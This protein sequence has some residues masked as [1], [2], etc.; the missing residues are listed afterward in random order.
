MTDTEIPFYSTFSSIIRPVVSEEK[1]KY[2]SVASL[3]QIKAFI[4]NLD[5]KNN[6]DFLAIAFNACVVNRVNKNDDVIDTKTA[7]DIYKSFINTPINIEHNRKNIIG[8]I[9]TAGFSEF[10]SDKPLSE[11]QV[12]NLTS[13]FNITLGGLIWKTVSPKI[14]EVVEEASDPTSKNYLQVS[15]SWELKFTGYNL[16]ILPANQKN[17]E[18][19]QIIT[20]A[21]EIDK[22]KPLLRA[23]KG[24]GVLEDGR[25]LYREASVNVSAMGIGI[26]ENPAAEVKG[27]ATEITSSVVVEVKTPEKEEKVTP[28]ENNISQSSILPVTIERIKDMK[29][30]SLKDITNEN[31]KVIEASVISDFITS[32]FNSKS[33]EWEAEKS[34]LATQLSKAQEEAKRIADEQKKSADTIKN[35]EASVNAL[36]TEKAEREKVDKFNQ[37]MNEVSQAYDFD[38][39]VQEAVVEE[40]KSLSS[41]EEFAKWQKK[42]SLLLK[43]FA[44]KKV[45]ADESKAQESKASIE[46]AIDK[47]TKDKQTTPN[48]STTTQSLKEKYANAFA[49]ENITIKL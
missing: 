21:E 45:K 17:I 10:G 19:G 13:P 7:L 5:S 12:K 4:P 44:K 46:D 33:K 20:S 37:R 43:G 16:I 47:G 22:L 27:I 39:E 1:D 30:T 6:D 41:D 15:A 8:V 35:L 2:L 28:I 32:E 26:T 34:S 42:A 31:L 40:I 14:A 11:E 29:I 23:N 18:N 3:E 48:S 49:K 25:R 38:K 24:S 36:N 9:L